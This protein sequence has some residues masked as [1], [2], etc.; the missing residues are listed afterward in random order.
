[1]L[2]FDGLDSEEKVRSVVF[3][4]GEFF[5]SGEIFFADR[6]SFVCTWVWFGSPE[7]VRSECVGTFFAGGLLLRL[8]GGSLRDEPRPLDLG[9]GGA[10]AS[11][12]SLGNFESSGINSRSKIVVVVSDGLL[13]MM[14]CR[15]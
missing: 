2:T 10:A 9:R 7:C 5:E 1:M 14:S 3:N 13:T 8:C 15:K 11:D 6:D 12:F 4:G